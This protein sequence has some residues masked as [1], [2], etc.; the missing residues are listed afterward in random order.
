[1]YLVMLATHNK[2]D[3]QVGRRQTNITKIR[4]NMV[5][6]ITMQNVTKFNRE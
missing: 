6:S 2:A 4:G 5:F 1:M 3:F